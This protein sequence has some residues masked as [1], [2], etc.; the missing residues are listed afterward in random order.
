MHKEGSVTLLTCFVFIVLVTVTLYAYR[1]PHWLWILLMVP[2]IIIFCVIVNFFRYPERHYKGDKLHDVIAP[3]DGTIVCIE[4]VYAV[5]RRIVTYYEAGERCE[6]DGELG[7]IKFGSRI[8]VYLP[9]DANILVKLKQ[10]VRGNTTAL[11]K[12]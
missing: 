2:L 11:A 1:A 4:E 6:V 12:I 5:A 8:D 10:T 9:L 3:S 7:F